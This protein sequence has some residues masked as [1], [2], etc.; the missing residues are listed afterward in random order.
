MTKI[1]VQAM[2]E[3]YTKLAEKHQGTSL[4]VAKFQADTDR[5]FAQSRLGLQTFPTI[6]LLPKN[7]PGYIKYPSERRDVD[8]LD[9]W[10]NSIT[11]THQS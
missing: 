3:Q 8:T 6:V 5:D 10:V 7:A 11:G 1:V 4:T 9:Q 2:E